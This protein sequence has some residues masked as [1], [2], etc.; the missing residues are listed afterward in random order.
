MKEPDSV[1]TTT[2][3]TAARRKGEDDPRFKLELRRE[4]LDLYRRTRSYRKV[5]RQLGISHKR[6]WVLVYE[7]LR[8]EL[9]EAI[10]R[11]ERKQ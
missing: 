9:A 3:K 1:A 4:A 11:D 8:L 6:A 7:A 5:G 2:D 10:H